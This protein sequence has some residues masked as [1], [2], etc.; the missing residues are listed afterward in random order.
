MNANPAW[1]EVEGDSYENT[2]NGD[3]Y[4]L[5]GDFCQ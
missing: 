1:L 2:I 5:C 4:E 3:G